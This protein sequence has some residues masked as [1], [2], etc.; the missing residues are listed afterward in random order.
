MVNRRELLQLGAAL[1]ALPL[2]GAA[3]ANPVPLYKVIF[4]G[5]SAAGQSFGREVT[6]LG[7]PELAH[8]VAGDVT[9]VWYHDLY[10]RWRRGPVAIA[11][12]TDYAAIF[13]LERL[14]WDFGMRTVFRA[15]HKV[16]NEAD[17]GPR[18][19]RTIIGLPAGL[20]AI[21]PLGPRP[22]HMTTGEPWLVSWV[23]APV[24]RI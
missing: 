8:A 2:L 3:R 14:A 19:A 1:G 13:C 21:A 12:L 15:D 9:D 7:S 5:R 18:V 10:P 23:I 20:T 4:D 17:W 11:G 6:R 16:G 22:E 24:R